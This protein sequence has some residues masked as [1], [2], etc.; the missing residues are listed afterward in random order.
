MKSS[1]ADTRCQPGGAP[2]PGSGLSRSGAT[3]APFGPTLAL[4]IVFVYAGF[5]AAMGALLLVDHPVPIPGLPLQQNQDA[6]TLL[7]LGSFVVILPISLVLGSRLAD[8]IAAGPNGPALSTLTA[9]LGAGLALALILVKAS[10]LFTWGDTVGVALAAALAWWI[11]AAVAIRRAAQARPWEGLLNLAP[12][13]AAVWAACGVLSFIVLLCL[14]NLA[15]VSLLGAVIGV[16]LL[17]AVLGAYDRLRPPALG[18]GW[19][20]AIDVLLVVLILLAVPDLIVVRPEQAPGNLPISLRDVD[21]PVPPELPARAGQRGARRAADAGR[22]R[23]AVRRRQHLSARRLVQARPDRLRHARLP[24]RGCS[25]LSSFAAGYCILRIAGTSP[26]AR[27][28]GAR[29]RESS[30][31]SSTPAYPI[32]SIPQDSTLRFGLPMAALLALVAG[33]R[34]PAR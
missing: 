17:V 3:T 21:H 22:H 15:S 2:D 7:Y 1:T 24:Q 9:A 16:A 18:R 27:G 8:R 25:A 6:E 4:S 26:P 29:R 34:W 19:R 33:E 11:A 10:V 31:S 13:A 12:A 32:D 20:I 28:L 5:L 23:L 30:R 14:T